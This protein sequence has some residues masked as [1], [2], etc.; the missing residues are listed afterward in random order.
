[1]LNPILCLT[2]SGVCHVTSA[3]D[4]NTSLWEYVAGLV[5]G[6]WDKVFI[7]YTFLTKPQFFE[8]NKIRIEGI[9][10]GRTGRCRGLIRGIVW[11]FSGGTEKPLEDPKFSNPRLHANQ[12]CEP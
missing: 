4:R 5:L 3:V 1:M 9:L 12:A 11:N 7:H 6:L 8:R 10:A 2:Q